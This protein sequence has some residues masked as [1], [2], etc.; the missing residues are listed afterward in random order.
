MLERHKW[1]EFG[2]FRIDVENNVLL[3][4][5]KPLSLTPKVFETLTILIR[6]AGTL[7]QKST[8]M[9]LIWHDRFVEESNLTFNIKMLRKALGDDAG[10]PRYVETVPRRGYRFIAEVKVVDEESIESRRAASS[11]S[12]PRYPPAGKKMIT[13]VSVIIFTGLAILAASLWQTRSF[14]TNLPVLLS[15]FS[16][17]KLTDTGKVPHAVISPN[18]KYIAYTSVVNAKEGLWIRHLES[19]NN[20]QIL[21]TSNDKYYGL[22]FGPDSETIFFNRAPDDHSEHP[23]IFRVPITG[24]I[25]V[26]IAERAQGGLSVSP[27]GRQISFVRHDDRIID[28]NSLMMVDSDGNNE[29]LIKISESPSMFWA[30]SMSP[31][32]KRIAA[33]HGRSNNSAKEVNL[34]EIDI[35]TGE[36]RQLTSEPFFH[37]RDVVWLPDQKGL[38]FSGN[39]TIGD[40]AV[41]W[42]FEFETRTAWPITKDSVS[43]GRLT[44]SDTA[45]NL[46]ATIFTGD[47]HLYVGDAK[48]S[49]EVRELTQARDG[50]AFTP[51]GKFVYAS[52]SAGTE[53]I[54]I[55]NAD[56][57]DQRQLTTNRGLDS[58]PIVSPDNR[59]IFFTS[60]RSGSNQIWRMNI[61]GSNQVQLTRKEGGYPRLV[62]P[63]GKFLYYQASI[64]NIVFK[65]PTDGGEESKILTEERGY[66]S[67]I[68]PDGSQM[69]YLERDAE[70]KKYYMSVMSIT[71]PNVTKRYSVPEKAGWAFRLKWSSDGKSLT[72]ITHDSDEKTIA[73]AQHLTDETPKFLLD[74]G[75]DDVMEFQLSPDGKMAAFI[76]GKWRHDAV[77]ITGLK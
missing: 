72:Y 11:A 77:L 13:L 44:L 46:V 16:S 62:T 52:D 64:T 28:R 26:K 15:D 9:E 54:W 19:S 35:E 61:D 8:L 71:D 55:M 45:E 30:Q 70:T 74:L 6:N 76:R 67:A 23:A 24:G 42:Q 51:D 32:G 75:R 41:I 34:V 39:E 48:G 53:D 2:D 14:T 60:N 12:E 37:I 33:A 31:D 73:W 7:V 43:Y 25:P 1:H 66:Y 40:P 58:D 49:S 56:G 47:F 57:S 27:D 68:S 59:F 29:R 18:G 17:I 50:F 63:D 20:T 4:N 38:L 65:V 10:A 3:R 21:P 5:G 22:A 69:A 36:Q